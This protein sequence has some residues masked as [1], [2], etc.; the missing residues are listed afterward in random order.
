MWRIAAIIWLCLT[1][2]ALAQFPGEAIFR[3]ATLN[4]Y[5][6]PA[7][8]LANPIVF[9]GI[10]AVSNAYAK[11]GSKAIQVTRASDSTTQDI[12]VLAN[13]NLNVTSAMTFAGTDAVCTGSVTASVTLTIT[14]CSSGTLHTLDTIVAPG[15]IQPAYLQNVGTCQTPPGTCTLN[16]A[17]TF[18]GTV[19][20][21]VALMIS[22]WYDQV[23][24]YCSGPCDELQPTA[25]N[26]PQLLFNCI[27]DKPCISFLNAGVIT[28]NTS[29]TLGATSLP[30]ISQPFTYS[31]ISAHIAEMTGDIANAGGFA[32][33]LNFQSTGTV[34]RFYSGGTSFTVSGLTDLIYHNIQGLYSGA[35]SFLNVDGIETGG[36]TGTGNS[37]TTLVIGADSNAGSSA[38]SGYINEFGI[39]AGTNATQRGNLCHNQ[40]QYYGTATSC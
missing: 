32:A 28:G 24:T 30:A 11:A 16:A 27:V 13:G 8:V 33:L 3:S 31:T 29:L 4:F 19:T 15:I 36:T 18:S 17:Q 5:T 34:L 7:D 39:W 35:S 1:V 9:Y 20:A 14:S 25:L 2:V 26:Q 12:N 38:L 37:G 6:G 21:T 23:G 10:R 22:K 40:Y